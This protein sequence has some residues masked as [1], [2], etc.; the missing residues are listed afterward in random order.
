MKRLVLL[1]IIVLIS[2]L[3]FSDA[4]RF[5]SFDYLQTEQDALQSLIAQDPLT[6]ALLFFSLYI[7]VTALSIPGAAV[8]TLAAGA[9]FGFW[10]G[11][12]LVSFAS[13]IGA[14]CAF[15]VARYL[16]RDY[17][18][19]KFSEK[20]QSI[21]QGI[22]KEGAFY[23]FSIRQIAV[24]PFFIVNLLFGLTSMKTVTF[25]WVSQLGMLLGTMAYVNAGTQLS[26]VS[27]I[28]DILS[29]NVLFSF[30]ILGLLPLVAKR[31]ITFIRNRKLLK[32]YKRPAHFEY[33]VVVIG[34]GS[35][36]L[37]SSYIA[38]AV[39]AKVALIEKH[40]MGGDCL[41]TG[42]VPSKA[43]I[44]S[45]KV[46][47]LGTRAEEF[48]LNSLEARFD[49]SKVM[50]RIQDIIQ[51]I[52]PHDS[53]KRY[54]SLGVDCFEGEAR[55]VSPY[56]VEVNGRTLT[57][58]SIIVATGAR[59]FVPPIPGL[60]QVDYYTSDT[61][62]DLREAP[63]KLVVL[64]GGPIGSELAQAFHRLGAETTQVEAH[65][66]VLSRE[67]KDISDF[68]CKRFRDEGITV[69]TK[70]RGERVEVE[71]DKKYLI[72][73]SAEG[74]AR[75]EFDTLLIALGRKANVNGFG[76]QE[77]GVEIAQ[78]GTLSHDAFLR[79]N[80]PNI[81]VC[82]D[83]AG[84]YQF[85]H[86]AGHQAWFASV[87][88]LLSPFWKFKV[89]YRVIPWCTFTDPEVARVGVNEAEA[90]EKGIKYRVT[91]YGIDDL[92]RAI[93]DSSDYGFVKIITPENSDKILGAA[94][95][96]EHAGDLLVEFI[97]AMKHGLG[98]NKI[99]GTI[100]VYPTLAEANKYTAGVWKKSTVSESALQWAE[101]FMRWQRK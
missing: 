59:P 48:G 53:V 67:D 54:Q 77:L 71:D 89:D 10:Q 73:S 63:K 45:A 64:G 62:W 52:E 14:T 58:R 26:T 93:T 97:F 83:V 30:A 80:Y 65:D 3:Y 87:N 35:A 46:A 25:F 32:N 60:E 69:L 88:A 8:L 43:L 92:D 34:A 66:C 55:I 33:N 99:L 11:L 6:S 37:V 2:L 90:E 91:K 5:L 56:E 20:L 94:I 38:S 76:L 40:K 9:L 4:T 61:I 51:K 22:K 75:V 12:L 1:A 44:R 101:R 36:G 17:V 7:L 18:Q 50:E 13:T 74:E 47:H 68:I 86:A 27:S 41:N 95:V 28:G 85:T 42:C 100:H 81:Y 49:F 72:C 70:H 57:T 29:F 82:G 39:K 21:N 84:P 23:L 15:L 24:F 79:T 96:G 98:L 31:S 16:L 19:A 78:S